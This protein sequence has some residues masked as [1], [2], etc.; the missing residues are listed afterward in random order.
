MPAASALLADAGARLD[1]F[2]V[3][4]PVC[5]PSRASLITGKHAHNVPITNNTIA[6]GCSSRQ[7][8]ESAEKD[9]MATR[10]RARGYRTGFAGKYLNRYGSDKAGGVQH[11]PPGWDEWLGLVGNSRYYNYTLSRNGVAEEHGDDPDADYLT[12]LVA[13]EAVAFIEEA[14]AGGQPQPFFY[15]ASPPGC[16]D[17]TDPPPRHAKKFAGA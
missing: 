12:D 2:F 17:P 5:C 7:W 4:T 3:T 9:T 16:H 1:S 10:L 14:S 8:Q 6:G 15:Y 13:R 11:V